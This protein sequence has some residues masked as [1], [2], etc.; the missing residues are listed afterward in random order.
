M[1]EVNTSEPPEVPAMSR[2]QWI[3]RLATELHEAASAVAA[4]TIDEMIARGALSV[5]APRR[6]TVVYDDP[7]AVARYEF[8]DIYAPTAELA[9]ARGAFL[10]ILADPFATM[11]NGWGGRE[12]T[13]GERE[14]VARSI[15]AAGIPP[16][17]ATATETTTEEGGADGEAGQ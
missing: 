6:W 11:P 7:E 15:I 1:I 17:W 14:S 16:S 12:A 5:G 9:E 4:R 8:T 13:M 10:A 2:E 3:E